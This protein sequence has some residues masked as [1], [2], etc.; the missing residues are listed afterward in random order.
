MWLLMLCKFLPFKKKRS[1]RE[2]TMLPKKK[3][4]FKILGLLCI[5]LFNR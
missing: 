4:I 2:N 1:S 3:Q 5:F